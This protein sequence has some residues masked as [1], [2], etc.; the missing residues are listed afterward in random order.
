MKRALTSAI[1]MTAIVMTA[2]FVWAGGMGGGMGG[3]MMGGGHMMDSYGNGRMGSNHYY[4]RDS[5]QRRQAARQRA[6]D[7]YDHDMRR[8]DRQIRDKEQALDAER[9]K[10]SPDRA[11]IEKLRR[12]LSDLEHRY[13]DRRAEFLSRWGRDDR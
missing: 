10:E 4:D 11:R 13:D 7:A 12:D 8:L 5:A 9:Q 6:Q 2:T 3:G 1:V